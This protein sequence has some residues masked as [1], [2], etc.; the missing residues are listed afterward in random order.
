MKCKEKSV[1]FIQATEG[2]AAGENGILGENGLQILAS[3]A[4]QTI[5]D[6]EEE[7]TYFVYF[8]FYSFFPQNHVVW[9]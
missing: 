4:D 5:S 1:E 3:A 8:C 6:S 9:I 2:R 7:G